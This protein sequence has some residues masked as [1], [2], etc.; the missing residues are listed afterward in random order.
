MLS[1][2]EAKHA[3][4]TKALQA[5]EEACLAEP[6]L[7]PPQE[8]VKGLWS[9]HQRERREAY[10]RLLTAV[11]LRSEPVPGKK[12]GCV[13]VAEIVPN[14][15][16]G[17]TGLPASVAFGKDY[18]KI[19]RSAS[20]SGTRTHMPQQDRLRRASGLLYL[21]QRGPLER[22]WWVST[23]GTGKSA[24]WRKAWMDGHGHV[25]GTFLGK[26]KGAPLGTP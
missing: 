7:V 10:R 12:L 13:W 23:R 1:E 25:L 22:E 11:R 14:V 2:A 5:A 21:Q 3:E 24:R 26:T 19:G 9:Q 4:A 16:A 18:I 8:V 15:Q 6:R 20:P 17:I